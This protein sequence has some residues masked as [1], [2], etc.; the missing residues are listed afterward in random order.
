MSFIDDLAA[1]RQKLLDGLDAN[2]GDINLRIF[3]DFYPD[4]AHF[5]YELL[6]NAEDAEATEAAFELTPTGCSFVHNGTRHFDENN[7]KAI[8][9]IFNSS[10]QNDPDK[11]GKFGVGFKS[12]F[13]YTDTPI[14]YSKNY[15]FRIIQLVLPESVPPYADLGELTR[16]EFP[17]NNTKKEANQAYLEVRAGLESL[18]ETTLLFLNNLQCITWKIGDQ[19]GAVLRVQH[20]DVHVEVLKEAANR[21]VVSSHWLRFTSPVT[22]LERQKVAVAFEL[23]F[24]GEQKTFDPKSPISK[25]LKIVPSERGRV[26]VF[27]PAE[28]ETSGL[29][30]H[31][32]APFVPELSRAS[33]KN[34]PA[35]LPLFEQL[36]QLAARSLYGIKTLG[37]LTGEFLSVLP[38]NDEAL[39]ERYRNIRAAI[40]REMREQP[41][42]P[43]LAKG[44]AP[45]K[46]L[47][48]AR[49]VFKELMSDNDLK[50]LLARDDSPTWAIAASQ[51][52]SNQDRFLSSLSIKVWDVGEFLSFLKKQA[53]EGTHSWEGKVNPEV[54][55]WLA[56]KTDEWHQQ[57]YAVLYRFIEDQGEFNDLR[58]VKI[59][60]LQ[61]H[62]YSSGAKCYFPSEH[63][64]KCE[65]FPRVASS[66]FVASSR[67]GQQ[68]DAKAF[69]ERIG[70]RQVGESEQISL[71]LKDRY[72]RESKVPADDVYLN[73]LKRFIALVENNPIERV[74]FKASYIFKLASERPTWGTPGHVYLD[75]PFKNT[76]LRHYHEQVESEKKKQGLSDWYR[77]CGVDLSKL[78]TFAEQLG[79]SVTFSEMFVRTNC[80]NNPKWG[81]LSQVAGERYTT[82]INEDFTTSPEV[83][84]LLKNKSIEFSRLVWQTLCFLGVDY[85][86]ATYQKN[87]KGGARYAESTLM[88]TLKNL[89]W[90]PLKNG[91][92]VKPRNAGRDGLLTGFAYDAGNK[93][94][95]LVQFGEEEKKRSAENIAKAQKRAELG[96]KSDEEFERAIAF[97]KLPLNEQ[98]RILTEHAQRN[99]Q[100]L[101]EFP[102]R[103]VRNPIIRESRVR[104]Q[105]QETP[106]K[107]SRT[108]Q[109]TVAIGYDAAKVA[110]KLY[111]KE[112][113]TND[114]GVMFCQV[115]RAPQP[116][117][118]PSGSHYFEA[119]EVDN[120]LAKRF[121][122]TFL[123]LCPNHAAM[124][125]YANS[126]KD[127]MQEQLAVATG[128]EVEVT[129]AGE[130]KIIQFTETHIADIKACLASSD[131]EDARELDRF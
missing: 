103:P 117:R 100:S 112:Q 44:H 60:R 76:G 65:L 83:V 81:Y 127:C 94:L 102:D 67:K 49:A 26:A 121:R 15:S 1:K 66:I 85:L 128:T 124:F 4:E 131:F 29:R 45:A 34:S 125:R 96:F 71:I 11:I 51:R 53:Y 21:T 42:T 126:Q 56:T 107:E 48:Q 98:E 20:G 35:N 36:A 84:R 37:L 59:V 5:I 106:N 74:R 113:Y 77:T 118:L 23:A 38:N 86:F 16:F 33:I 54:M 52:N 78:T 101:E 32:H 79:C 130:T 72:S 13:V 68:A 82:P 63:S 10:K 57:L 123:A 92:F 99:S 70:V 88:H 46:T 12:V 116:F 73:D 110:A 93:W 120:A 109:R 69:L 114:S 119:V 41:L 75:S 7:I 89:D 90:V 31:L 55:S 80:H 95:E 61:N 40:V 58:N 3:E 64:D 62:S 30:F 115:C 27:F 122:E 91:C 105:A 2:E 108:T 6:Q 43:T 104:D 25:Q 47:I 9:G 111:L 129:L 18:S 8:T 39:P 28:K 17:F 24:L 22:T 50:F 19:N 14:I 97:V 87:E